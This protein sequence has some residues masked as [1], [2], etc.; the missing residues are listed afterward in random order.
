MN[1]QAKV[2][3]LCGSASDNESVELCAAVLEE[4]GIPHDRQILSAHRRGDALRD[5]VRSAEAA[6]CE[7]FIAMAGMAA[8][9]PGV[10]ASL[11]TR[12]VLGVP[13]KG[14]V[15]DGLDALLSVAQMPKGVPVAC[16]AV[17]SAGARNAA[18][19]AAQVLALTDASLA[20]RLR[21]RKQAM[22]EGKE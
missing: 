19:F 22:A 11:T 8:H 13:L 12:P 18:H 7:I 1:Q 6:G 10:V 4:Y 16:F 15:L 5:Y 3:I 14:G 9:L 21:Q 2:A 17:G 20:Q